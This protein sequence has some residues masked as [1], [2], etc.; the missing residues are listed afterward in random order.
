MPELHVIYGYPAKSVRTFAESAGSSV[1]IPL[2]ISSFILNNKY[3]RRGACT[4]LSVTPTPS[5]VFTEVY[6]SLFRI[7]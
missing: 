4:I 1:F 6:P 2:N 7:I 5:F 3:K